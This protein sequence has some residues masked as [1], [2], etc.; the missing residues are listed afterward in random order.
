MNKIGFVNKGYNISSFKSLGDVKK[1]LNTKKVGHMGTLDPLATGCLPFASDGLTSLIPFVPKLPKVYVVEI[2]FGESSKSIDA[3]FVDLDSLNY[4]P[5]ELDINQFNIYLDSLIPGYR[6]VPPD[7]SAKKINGVRAY[8]LARKGSDVVL[9]DKFVDF[10]SYKVLEFKNPILKLEISCGEGF[11][12][13]SL[14][15]DIS[16][17]FSIPAFMYSLHRS[18][19]GVFDLD[20]SE[21]LDSGEIK[22]LNLIDVFPDAEFINIDSSDYKQLEFGIAPKIDSLKEFVFVYFEKKLVYYKI[23]KDSFV[24]QRFLIS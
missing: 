22:F 16:N 18:K 24:K 3:E 5:V 13:R 17:K 20:K 6:Q 23:Q 2:Y 10:F 1:A 8:D 4:S 19:V 21:S 9:K 7:F 11:Y 12:V 14:V 15:N